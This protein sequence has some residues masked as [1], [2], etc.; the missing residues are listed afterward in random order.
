MMALFPPI[1]LSSS[2][3]VLE[4]LPNASFRGVLDHVQA[5]LTEFLK[6]PRYKQTNLAEKAK[7]ELVKHQRLPVHV[8][9]FS[10]RVDLL[11]V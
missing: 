10:T 1:C 4:K 8:L 11:H 6:L 7:S 5:H 9:K 3:T 2:V